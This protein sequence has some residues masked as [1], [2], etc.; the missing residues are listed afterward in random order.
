MI[1]QIQ[2]SPMDIFGLL[3]PIL[4]SFI[5]A[6]ITNS[7][8][9]HLVSLLVCVIFAVAVNYPL[10]NSVQ[11]LVANIGVI[12]LASNTFYNVWWSKTEMHQTISGQK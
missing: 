5:N 11:S 2:M 4:I 12:F 6:K 7:D 1:G 9:R 8:L 10:I 3:L